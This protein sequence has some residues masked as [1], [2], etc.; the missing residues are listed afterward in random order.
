MRIVKDGDAYYRIHEGVSQR[1]ELK[2]FTTSDGKRAFRENDDYYVI[3]S[4]GSLGLYDDEGL[5][6][7][8]MRLD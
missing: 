5:I 6:R 3:E 7:T 4:D 2:E 8:A 1:Y